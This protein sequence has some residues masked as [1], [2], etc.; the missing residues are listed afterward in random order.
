MTYGKQ[1]HGGRHY[2]EIYSVKESIRQGL[3]DEG[4]LH[5]ILD[6]SVSGLFKKPEIKEYFNNRKCFKPL[7]DI[8]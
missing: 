2:G 6:L 3:L 5:E 4:H 8:L 1:H 7:R